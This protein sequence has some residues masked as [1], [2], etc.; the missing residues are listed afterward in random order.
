VL[1]CGP[2]ASLAGC[3]SSLC[4]PA[5][6]DARAARP[7]Y[8]EKIG[9]RERSETPEIALELSLQPWR[10]FR[11]DG[12]IMFS[13]ILTPLPALGIEFDVVRGK[14]P[15]IASPV[16]RCVPLVPRPVLTGTRAG[17]QCSHTWPSLR[18][19]LLTRW[20][21]T[22]SEVF[23]SNADVLPRSLERVRAL[24]TLDDPASSLP[25][26]APVLRALRAEVGGAAAV[27][28]FVG[29]PWT[30]AAYAMEGAAERHCLQTKAR[31][32]HRVG[33]VLGLGREGG[34]RSS[35]P[36]PAPRVCAQAGAG[37]SKE[38]SQCC[39]E[40][41]EARR[42][43]RTSPKEPERGGL[44]RRPCARLP[45][46]QNS[47][48]QSDQMREAHRAAAHHCRRSGPGRARRCLRCHAAGAPPGPDHPRTVRP[49]STYIGLERT[50]RLLFGGASIVRHAAG[51]P[52]CLMLGC[53]AGGSAS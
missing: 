29:T 33:A 40:C 30:L 39:C 22:S 41:T 26:V 34:F 25:F 49:S 50:E 2:S 52:Q 15:V 35:L 13:D 45:L 36:S 20:W 31:A 21:Q 42:W 37:R 44:A 14:G 48:S 4:V 51:A 16:R 17:S 23:I 38:H 7:R 24:R 6:C 9:F 28:G 3:W 43:C 19:T 8:S 53:A 1:V 46:P 10:A 27:L 18:I 12:V 32:G 11:P 47:C 5:G